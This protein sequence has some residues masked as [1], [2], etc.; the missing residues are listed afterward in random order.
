M[1]KF[2]DVI[3]IVNSDTKK[4]D[5]KRMARNNGSDYERSNWLYYTYLQNRMY[6]LLHPII[7]LAWF[8]E[9]K[10]DIVQ[11]IVK[12]INTNAHHLTIKTP[13]YLKKYRLPSTVTEPNGVDLVLQNY[14]TYAHREF[15]RIDIQSVLNDFTNLRKLNTIYHIMKFNG[16]TS[17]N[18]QILDKNE[19]NNNRFKTDVTKIVEK[20]EFNDSDVSEYEMLY[21]ILC[22]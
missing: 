19:E 22:D 2:V 3:V 12:A 7:D 4:C 11:I 18:C 10:S 1:L 5:L 13:I 6:K 15:A 9:D 8:D 20:S 16:E 21:S 17:D 14:H